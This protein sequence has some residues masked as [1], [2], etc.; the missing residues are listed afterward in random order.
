M[1]MGTPDS[2]ESYVGSIST[3]DST[4]AFPRT[5][6]VPTPPAS[7]SSPS[8]LS[9][10]A[11]ALG[12]SSP[13]PPATTPTPT[14]SAQSED[15]PEAGP[16]TVSG[17]ETISPALEELAAPAAQDFTPSTSERVSLSLVGTTGEQG[18]PR[19]LKGVSHPTSKAVPS[20]SERVPSSPPTELGAPTVQS[21]LQAGTSAKSSIWEGDYDW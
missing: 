17:V 2:G 10:S 4:D 21:R 16:G 12:P 20:T 9:S 14:P 13:Q 1:G 15:R 19:T 3:Q 5:E 6:E 11:S 7:Q 18:V 8:T